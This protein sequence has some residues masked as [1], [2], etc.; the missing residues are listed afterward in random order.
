MSIQEIKENVFVT[1]NST[2]K[3]KDICVD[4]HFSCN[5]LKHDQAARSI[6]A[7]VLM[8][9]CS[10]YDTREKLLSA[11]M[12]NYGSKLS[13]SSYMLGMMRVL[14]LRTSVLNGKYVN[15]QESVYKHFELIHEVLFHPLW[16]AKQY[17][18][19]L[20]KNLKKNL[21]LEIKNNNDRP[22]SYANK[23]ADKL[24]GG[25][26]AIVYDVKVK[27][28]TIEQVMDIYETILHNARVDIV[29]TG[30]VDSSEMMHYINQFFPF[31]GRQLN[32]LTRYCFKKRLREKV[33]EHKMQQTQLQ[34]RYLLDKDIL[35]KN[36]E[37]CV[38]ANALLGGFSNSL[39]FSEI[40]E[41]RGLCYY[42]YSQLSDVN[43]ML[44]IYTG[45]AN[46]SIELVQTLIQEQIKSIQ[47]GQFSEE[48]LNSCKRLLINALKEGEDSI[49][50]VS[51]RSYVKNILKDTV[52]ISQRIQNIQNVQKD[53]VVFVFQHLSLQVNYV[54]KQKDD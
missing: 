52:S 51:Y 31:K 7:S 9:S 5:S 17:P 35:L 37:A 18:E 8:E 29:I 27:P 36:Y 15:D 33:V 26:Y 6:L 2:K 49:Y 38:V 34:Q 4:I 46:E 12:Q 19:V 21:K 54:Y 13:C 30:D 11:M 45:I 28:V 14:S 20:F 50:T 16:E 44:K 40:R 32:L 24:L 43:A 41:K 47:E 53:D 48:T 25:Q 1:I 3:F 10:R 22:I 23:E 39:L 42:I